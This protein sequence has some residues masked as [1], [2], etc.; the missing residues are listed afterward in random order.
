MKAQLII[1]GLVGAVLG[2]AMIWL[3]L[4]FRIGS[5]SLE[6]PAAYVPA[7]IVGAVLTMAMRYVELRFFFER[8]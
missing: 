7:A 3:G 2:A 8:G 5:F 1:A 6:T 4:N